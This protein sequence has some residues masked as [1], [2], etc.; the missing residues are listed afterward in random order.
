MADFF[1]NLGNLF[2]GASGVSAAK[3]SAAAATKN[4]NKGAKAASAPI[5]AGKTEA[6]GY[7]GQALAPWQTIFGQG[8]P[9]V[10]TYYGALG[11]GG[12]GAQAAAQ[13]AFTASPAYEYTLGQGLEGLSRLGTSTGQLGQADMNAM[14]FAHNLSNQ[15]YQQWLNNLS[16]GFGQETAGAG[17]QS[18][19][20]GNMSNIATGAARDL[21][22]IQTNRYNTI[23]AAQSQLP[24]AINAANMG[25]AANS[26]S[27]LFGLG[28]LAMGG[29]GGGFGTPG[30]SANWGYNNLNAMM[31]G[32][33]GWDTSV[34]PA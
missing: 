7:Q 3:A 2:T 25:G 16:Q 31:G 21:S 27:A 26:L 34:M 29:G 18:N 10:N 24:L 33:G 30:S 19:A 6:L 12:P 5:T 32:S 4:A 28:G 8:Q 20:Y 22:Q 14:Q 15:D 9:A 11:I 13:N 17:G 23:G 1:S